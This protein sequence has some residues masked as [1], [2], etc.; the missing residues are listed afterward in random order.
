VALSSVSGGLRIGEPNDSYE[1][2]ADRAAD[3]VMA[4]GA[5]K[6]HWSLLSLGGETSVQRKCSCEASGGLGEC[7][8]CKQEKEDK[9]LQ[10]KAI[11]L[12]EFGVAPGIVHEVLN[13]PGQPLDRATRDFF[14]PRFGMDFSKVRV[15]TGSLAANSA[16]A[17][18]SLAYTVG[19]DIVFGRRQYSATSVEGRRLLGHELAHTIQQRPVLSRQPD[20]GEGARIGLVPMTAT[21]VRE[22]DQPDDGAFFNGVN[23]I[24]RRGG[25]KVFQTRVVSGNPGSKES[26][27]NV[28]PIPDGKYRI[29][30]QITRPPVTKL[31]KGICGAAGIGSGYQELTSTDQSPCSS[32][33]HY[34]T[35]SCPTSAN[36]SQMCFTPVGCWGAKRIR[37]EGS[38]TV[39]TSTGKNV[40]RDGF[41]IHGG[42]HS[43]DVT[44]GCVKTFDNGLFDELRKFK[45]TVPF[46]VTKVVKPE[47]AT[48]SH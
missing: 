32:P 20:E 38:A 12:A 30:P 9:M 2:E 1:R 21:A 31:Q 45:K 8:Q 28:G 7:E 36:P 42:D 6:R 24:V 22:A 19:N 23:I 16:K 43:V 41:Y 29:S 3:E 40:V 17:V 10:R 46:W 39:A 47:P 44:S 34:C 33:N 4:G 11:G 5:V 13:S 15:H 35:V 27:A 14:E 25:E 18:N 26:E 37:I 48:L